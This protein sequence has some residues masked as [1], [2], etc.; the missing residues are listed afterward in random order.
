MPRVRVRN[1]RYRWTKQEEMH[2]II[3][4]QYGKVNGRP[5]NTREITA[6]MNRCFQTEKTSHVVQ[7]FLASS[8][9]RLPAAQRARTTRASLAP[10]AYWI[11]AEELGEMSREVSYVLYRHGLLDYHEFLRRRQAALGAVQVTGP[12][13]SAS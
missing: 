2:C 11:T 10:S 7:H 12:A 9:G 1:P 3:L 13:T 4:R 8:A 5:I 6:C